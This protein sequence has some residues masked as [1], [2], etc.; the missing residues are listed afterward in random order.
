MLLRT[1]RMWL[2]YIHLK[3]KK[4]IIHVRHARFPINQI[5]KYLTW[6]D[7]F[8]LPKYVWGWLN[9]QNGLVSSPFLLLF[10]WSW[11][12]L[13]VCFCVCFCKKKIKKNCV[14]V[15][16]FFVVVVVCFCLFALL[17]VFVVVVVVL[18][19]GRIF[20]LF[21]YHS[22]LTTSYANTERL[23][24]TLIYFNTNTQYANFRGNPLY[25]STKR[26]LNNR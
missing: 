21:F 26:H 8:I 3:K 2:L 17:F 12:D 10:L 9:A 22:V 13:C 7:F 15:C 6:P 4:I 20:K 18:E 24:W 19:E 1:L 16:L 14:C 25:Q 5:K 23:K 11:S